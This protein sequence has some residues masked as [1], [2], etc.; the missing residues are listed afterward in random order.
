MDQPNVYVTWSG[1]LIP[2]EP[3]MAHF[4]VAVLD[5]VPLPDPPTYLTR[6][7]LGGNRS[8]YPLDETIVFP[9]IAPPKSGKHLLIFPQVL[10][11][12]LT[13]QER[14]AWAEYDE[15][16]AA[17]VAEWE[18]S[19]EEN[20]DKLDRVREWQ[21]YMTSYLARRRERNE[22]VA[23]FALL[24]GVRLDPPDDDDWEEIY[25]EAGIVVPTAKTE[26]KLFYLMHECVNGAEEQAELVNF[27][28]EL[29]QTLRKNRE[30]AIRSAEATFRDPLSSKRERA[31]RSSGHAEA[32]KTREVVI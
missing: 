8:E 18:E 25:R 27:I 10:E 23:R 5:T 29:G 14:R 31:T 32:V 1:K 21:E 20:K 17:L 11:L 28:F 3:V 4:A 19:P 6:P 22:K 7:D 2:C 24:K 13:T 12:P 15:A 9:D 16:K 30:E 26:R